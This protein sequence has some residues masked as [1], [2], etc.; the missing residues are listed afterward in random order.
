[1]I[2]EKKAS[3][4]TA[5]GKREIASTRPTADAPVP[6]GRCESVTLSHA[7]PAG[8]SLKRLWE[9]RGIPAQLTG[10]S[11]QRVAHHE[12]SHVVLLE[13][14]GCDITEVA[15]APADGFCLFSFPNDGLPPVDSSD[16]GEVSAT[17]AAACHAGLM[18]EMLF[19]GVPWLGPVFYPSYP[20]Y[21]TADEILMARFGRH[22]SAAHAFS[23]RLALH[24]LS[25]QWDR[26]REVADRLI[27]NGCW[28]PG[29]A[30]GAST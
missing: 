27:V 19:T 9:W 11:L 18:G 8:S 10:P 2:I 13:W 6:P 23:Q 29:E 17:A 30:S 22:S 4:G 21:Q 15:A 3:T 28:A 20:D 14:T 12:A 16:S 7:Y 5:S 25:A 26:V 1:M 24:V